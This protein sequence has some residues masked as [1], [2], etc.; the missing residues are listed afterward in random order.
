VPFDDAL[1]RVSEESGRLFDPDVVAAFEEVVARYTGI[2]RVKDA[3]MSIALDA[4]SSANETYVPARPARE[5]PG[6][7]RPFV[8]PTR[9]RE[10]DDDRPPDERRRSAVPPRRV[11]PVPPAPTHAPPRTVATTPTPPTPSA[12]PTSLSR[13][14]SSAARKA[15]TAAPPAPQRR[16]R[17]RRTRRTRSLF[18]AGIYVDAAIRGAWSTD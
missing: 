3:R 7:D 13:S 1:R 12:T 8:N 2:V 5:R 17:V 18:S 14:T 15:T 11:A 9:Q 4:A 16:A 10:H 6:E